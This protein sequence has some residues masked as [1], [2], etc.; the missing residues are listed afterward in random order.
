MKKVRI[1]FTAESG[2][3]DFDTTE[4]NIGNIEKFHSA[5]IKEIIPIGVGWDTTP[6]T[7]Q[8][9]KTHVVTPT[10]SPSETAQDEKMELMKKKGYLRAK[11]FKFLD[12]CTIEELQEELKKRKK[13]LKKAV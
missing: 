8:P 3:P 2:R 1:I 12:E 6:E 4:A 10:K 11:G 7:Y 13:D 9:M 5:I